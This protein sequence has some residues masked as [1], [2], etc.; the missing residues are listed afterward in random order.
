[1]DSTNVTNVRDAV[2]ELK[3]ELELQLECLAD[4]CQCRGGGL[5]WCF[6]R[7]PTKRPVFERSYWRFNKLHIFNYNKKKYFQLKHR[8]ESFDNLSD[9][10]NDSVDK[11]KRSHKGSSSLPREDTS[12]NNDCCN[13]S[14][15]QHQ[16][17]ERCLSDDG[18]PLQV[19]LSFF[20]SFFLSFLLSLYFL[21]LYL[22]F[23]FFLSFFF[24]M[25]LSFEL[26]TK[27][28]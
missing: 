13:N 14:S 26:T 16:Q 3:L 21:I 1:M 9:S 18:V 19:C 5:G 17:R 10:C 7:G 8:S 11:L 15:E 20:R 28:I 27:K 2:G 12:F 23:N 6:C 25:F 22:C 4:V 24:L